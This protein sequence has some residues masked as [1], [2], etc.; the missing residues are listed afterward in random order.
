MQNASTEGRIKL[1]RPVEII[2]APQGNFIEKGAA[3]MALGQINLRKLAAE[4]FQDPNQLLLD[5]LTVE[6]KGRGIILSNMTASFKEGKFIS[7]LKGQ[8]VSSPH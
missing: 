8:K 3:S 6:M 2:E 4:K 5:V 7:T 1:A